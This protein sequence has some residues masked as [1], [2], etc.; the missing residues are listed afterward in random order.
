[1]RK[2]LVWF[3]NDLR[4]ADNPALFRA[5]ERGSVIPVF[6]WAPE[7][8]EPCLREPLINGGSMKV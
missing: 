6:I 7:E 3:R 8:E 1:M 5:A 4:V 2:T